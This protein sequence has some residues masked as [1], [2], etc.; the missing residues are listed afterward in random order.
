MLIS[1]QSGFQRVE[2]M[3][4]RGFDICF[5][6]NLSMKCIPFGGNW[7]YSHTYACTHTNTHTHTHSLMLICTAHKNTSFQRCT[8]TNADT[9]SHAKTSKGFNG[10]TNINMHA[11]LHA[12]MFCPHEVQCTLMQR[13]VYTQQAESRPLSAPKE[14]HI[15]PTRKH[16]P[17]LT[18]T[19]AHW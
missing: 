16:T 11:T 2:G 3:Q 4:M 18:H 8:Q 1:G 12:S 5:L 10:N 14:K 19:H 15:P 9:H 6:I 17:T 13:I 7:A